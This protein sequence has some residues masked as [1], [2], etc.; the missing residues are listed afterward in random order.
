MKDRSNHWPIPQNSTTFLCKMAVALS[1]RSS[2]I[3]KLDKPRKTTNQISFRLLLAL[4]TGGHLLKADLIR[5]LR[6][7]C[8][9]I[10]PAIVNLI[11]KGLILDELL[12]EHQT[13]NKIWVRRYRY[14]I[15]SAG[16]SYLET[17]IQSV[18]HDAEST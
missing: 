12:L 17:F 18:L 3:N 15:S 2:E 8:K 14:R 5:Q 6:T 7:N 1:K 9:S 16:I 4:Y 11:G 10:T 13:K